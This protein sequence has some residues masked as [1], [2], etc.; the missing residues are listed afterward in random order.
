MSTQFQSP[1]S[2]AIFEREP[3]KNVK[4]NQIIFGP[5]R[6]AEEAEQDKIKY[7]F[8]DDNYYVDQIGPDNYSPI[9]L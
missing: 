5:Y 9:H 2:F 3:R 6:S 8:V 4:P 1:P 7:G